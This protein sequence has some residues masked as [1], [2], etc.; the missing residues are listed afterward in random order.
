MAIVQDEFGGTTG[1]VTFEDV[2]EQLVG[3]IV[4]GTDEVVD[5][6]TLARDNH[7][8]RIAENS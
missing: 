3:E 6:R 5:L 1:V 8:A 2:I 7:T 4:D